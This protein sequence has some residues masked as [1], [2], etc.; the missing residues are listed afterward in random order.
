MA[1][2]HIQP[3]TLREFDEF[4]VSYIQEVD[5]ARAED[6][7]KLEKRLAELERPKDG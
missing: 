7:R 3:K 1:D 5:A 6:V 2:P 4:L